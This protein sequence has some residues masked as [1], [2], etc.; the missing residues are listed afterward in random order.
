MPTS[1]LDFGNSPRTSSKITIALGTYGNVVNVCIPKSI[2]RG[3][4]FIERYPVNITIEDDTLIIEQIEDER[5]PILTVQGVIQIRCD[6]FPLIIEE[7][8]ELHDLIVRG[9]KVFAMLPKGVRV[10]EIPEKEKGE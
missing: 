1:I 2:R 5:L 9:G 6:R 10:R 3:A 4:E 7:K 8:I